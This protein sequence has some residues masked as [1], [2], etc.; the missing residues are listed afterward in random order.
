MA[1]SFKEA[2]VMGVDLIKK[3]SFL[4]CRGGGG[5]VDVLRLSPA[6][7]DERSTPRKD[8]DET[9]D[10]VPPGQRLSSS[11]DGLSVVIWRCRGEDF[12]S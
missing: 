9:S 2:V 8:Q 4:L 7:E 1:M 6:N 10:D 3:R 11:K 12:D 5:E